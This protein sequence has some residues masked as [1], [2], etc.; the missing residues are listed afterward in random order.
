MTGIRTTHQRHSKAVTRTKRWQVLRMAILERDGFRCKDCG[1]G[2][3][4]EIDHV[5]PVRT[6]PELSYDPD[7]LQALC[8]SCHTRK[9][10]LECGHPPLPEVRK[11]WND[12]VRSLQVRGPSYSIPANLRP[13]AVPV[14]I[15]CGPPGAGKS[16]YI[17][18]RAA[19]GDMVIDFDLYLKALGAEKWTTDPVAV[20]QAFRLRDADLRSLATRKRGRVWLIK[21]APT[22]AERSAWSRALLRVTEVVLAVDPETCKARIRAD[23]ERQHAVEKMCAAVDD[24]WSAY[25]ANGTRTPKPSIFGEHHA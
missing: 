3:R 4:L 1:L 22:M 15:V 14:T 20:R 19:D 24:W 9:T 10:R 23:P 13:S 16:T 21:S 25:A 8:P 18:E 11:E 7:N 12:L 2:G 6:H 5:K 17:R